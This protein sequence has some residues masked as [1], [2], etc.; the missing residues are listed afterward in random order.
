MGKILVI[1]PYEG[2]RDL[3]SEV[4]SELNKDIRIEVGDLYKGLTI[5]RDLENQ[6]FDVIIS[7]GATARL[8]RE[9]CHIPVVEVKIS[10]YDI[11]RSLT[12]VK[13]YQGKIGLMSYLNT[14]LGA[15]AIGTLLEMNLTFFPIGAE[16]EVEREIKK[17]LEENIQ[18]I[19]GDVIS[20]SVASRHGLKTILITSGREAVIESIIEAEQMAHYTNKE[21]V[22]RE[23]YEA[24]FNSHLEALVA[25]DQQKNI[26]AV[27]E[28]ARKILHTD[29]LVGKKA[30]GAYSFLHAET[31][32]EGG[33]SSFEQIINWHGEDLIVQSFPFQANE[34]FLGSVTVLQPASKIQMVE[35]RFR[36]RQ[37]S[38]DYKATIHFNHLVSHSASMKDIIRSAKKFSKSDFPLLIFGEPGTG[39]QSIAQAIHNGSNRKESPFIFVN[40]EAFNDEQLEYELWGSDGE[41]KRAGAFEL[42][43]GGTLF[44]D[45]IGKLPIHLQG[46]LINVLLENRITRVE[47]AH[48]I[49]VKARVMAANGCD[50]KDQLESG[51]FRLDLYHLLNGGVLQVP[52]LRERKDDIEE[53]VRWFIASYNS[54]SGKQIVGLRTEVLE[55][56]KNAEWRG[57]VQQ[58]KRTVEK[59]CLVSSGPFIE[60]EEVKVILDDL[61]DNHPVQIKAG[62]DIR[63]KTLDQ[64]EKDVIM[65]VLKEEDYNQSQVAKRLGINRSTLWRKIKE[66]GNITRG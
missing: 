54:N 53:L 16:D 14:I 44:I 24:I 39:K 40:C 48:S 41:Y 51:E 64:I 25:V 62:L 65:L 28:Q 32:L 58:L 50:L 12:L 26:V 55:M 11:L 3:F 52:P 5:A 29:E 10:G 43:H 49:P 57:N 6:G 34:V 2:L 9:H 36:N 59:M 61:L 1:A 27:N 20:T 63:G 33:G 31:V 13:G 45:A 60:K 22:Q 7:R 56:L 30:V 66:L 23:F 18:V 15:D 46:K 37:I 47:G 17:A 4:N 35:T 19:I 8:L 21:R 38:E 42:A